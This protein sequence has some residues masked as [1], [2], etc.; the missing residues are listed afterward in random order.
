MLPV[1]G[2]PT[3]QRNRPLGIRLELAHGELLDDAFLG[4]DQTVGGLHPEPGALWRYPDYPCRIVPGKRRYPI[5]IG[6]RDR[7]FRRG[8][9]HAGQTFQFS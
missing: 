6:R 1:P 3:K 5:Q 9:M 8:R 7:I 4:L 2:G